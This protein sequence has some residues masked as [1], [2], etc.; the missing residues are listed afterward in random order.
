M[1]SMPSRFSEP[2]QARRALAGLPSSADR[3]VAVPAHGEFGGDDQAV[4]PALDRAADQLLVGEG[5]IHLGGVEEGDAEVDRLV[6]GA[7]RD[8][9][10]GMAVDDVAAADHRH[11]ADAD[12]GDLEPLAEFAVFHHSLLSGAVFS[13]VDRD[14]GST[15]PCPKPDPVVLLPD[16]ITAKPPVGSRLLHR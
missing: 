4:A 6:D 16:P 7:D 1:V 15:D 12:G 3:L 11:A 14:I 10:V 5:A 2:S 8:V 13:V 9:V